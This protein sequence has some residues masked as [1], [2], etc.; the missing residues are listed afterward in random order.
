MSAAA[1]I[2]TIR[3]FQLKFCYGYDFHTWEDARRLPDVKATYAVSMTADGTPVRFYTDRELDDYVDTFL[4]KDAV[5]EGKLP[6]LKKL[7]EGTE[8]GEEKA[9]NTLWSKSFDYPNVELVAAAKVRVHFLTAFLFS[10]V[11]KSILNS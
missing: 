10:P 9:I 2:K 1:E 3:Y 11:L 7:L 8:T 5:K 4:G 6:R